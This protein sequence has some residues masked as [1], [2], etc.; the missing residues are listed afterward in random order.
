M[1]RANYLGFILIIIFTGCQL[2]SV[3]DTNGKPDMIIDNVTYSQLPRCF[4][5]SP[6][7]VIC[8]GPE[9]EFTLKIKNIGTAKVSSPLFILNSR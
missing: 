4:E 1:T 7:G 5:G 2:N 3:N 9:F 6:S 8:G